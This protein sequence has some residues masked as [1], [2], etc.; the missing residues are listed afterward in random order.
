[1]FLLDTRTSRIEHGIDKFFT[2]PL[3]R[4]PT[5]IDDGD[6]VYPSPPSPTVSTRSW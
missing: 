1:L 5:F 3:L 6:V 4:L 2:V